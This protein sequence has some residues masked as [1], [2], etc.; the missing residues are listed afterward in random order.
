MDTCQQESHNPEL[1]EL[2]DDAVLRILQVKIRLGLFENPYVSEEAEDS[3]K[4]QAIPASHL[5]QARDSARKSI[6][7]LQNNSGILPLDTG[8]HQKLALIGP[9][10]DDRHNSMGCWAWKGRRIEQYT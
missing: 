9:L 6:V 3:L 8:K 4:G 1:L 5:A 7:L 10:A 2:L